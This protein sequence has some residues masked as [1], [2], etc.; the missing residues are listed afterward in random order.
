MRLGLG[1][2][3]CAWALGVPGFDYEPCLNATG[4]IRRAA[5]LGLRLVQLADN[6]PVETFSASNLREIKNTARGHGVDLELGTRGIARDHLRRLL[7][8]CSELDSPILRVVVDTPNDHPSSDEII[9][10]FTALIPELERCGVT[11][12]IENHD[13]FRARAL[14]EMVR[15]ILSPA[16]GVCLDTVNS[17]GA[18]EGPQA[19]VA[20][21][22]PFVVNLHVKD[23]VVRRARHNMGFEITGTPAGQG[24]L[25]IP[26]LL[27]ELRE[28]GYDPN[29]IVEHWPAPE[30]LIHA[31]IEKELQ[32]CRQSVHYLR[33]FIAE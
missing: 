3:A 15:Q 23:F 4:L 21:L 19:V 7:D 17:F 30:P 25:D 8:L 10:R 33:Q 14:A 13:R 18:L 28:G 22:A 9:E 31:T 20:E 29:A 32:W 26:W 6:V 27:A 2:Y 24:Q 12:A 11:I 5:D 16:I 1:S